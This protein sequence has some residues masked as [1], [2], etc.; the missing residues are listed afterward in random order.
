MNYN[1]QKTHIKALNR[2]L[3]INGLPVF[4]SEYLGRDSLIRYCLD[5]NVSIHTESIPVSWLSYEPFD[6][7]SEA[8][9]EEA[10]D[11]GH[12]LKL[13]NIFIKYQAFSL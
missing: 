8:P 5:N 1:S 6:L 12:N 4:E 13:S 10:D 7:G 2:T 3:K 11:W 9:E